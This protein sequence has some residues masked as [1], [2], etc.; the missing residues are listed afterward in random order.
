MSRPPTAQLAEPTLTSHADP[1][2][3]AFVRPLRELLRVGIPVP[4]DAAVD[5]RVAAA[6][7]PDMREDTQHQGR[8]K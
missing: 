7:D 5:A 4:H 1:S 6:H 2:P 8:I 3:L